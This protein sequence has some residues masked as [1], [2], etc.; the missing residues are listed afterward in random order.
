MTGIDSGSTIKCYMY[1][2]ILLIDVNRGS[3]LII[4]ALIRE[5]YDW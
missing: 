4:L 3:I 2:L 1:L 5:E